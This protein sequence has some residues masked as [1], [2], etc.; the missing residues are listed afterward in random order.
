LQRL[1]EIITTLEDN[2]S[3][4]NLNPKCEPQLGRRGLYHLVGGT[5]NAGAEDAMMWT[6]NFSDGQH[7]LLDI[8]TRS[9]LPFATISTAATQL[10]KAGLLAKSGAAR[11]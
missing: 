4:V 10:E 6:L 5:K 1:L 3:Y 11:P 8:A 9:G 2:E 7:S